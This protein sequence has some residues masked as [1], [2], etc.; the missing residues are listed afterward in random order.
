MIYKRCLYCL[1]IASLSL[2]IVGGNPLACA[3]GLAVA[4]AFAKDD[5]LNN[6]VARGAQFRLFAL[7][8]L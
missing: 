5:L 6:V 3:A 7:F 8:F 2:F 1:F 4:E